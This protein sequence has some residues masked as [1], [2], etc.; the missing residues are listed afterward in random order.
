MKTEIL[1]KWQPIW[2]TVSHQELQSNGKTT[3]Y[4]QVLT[5]F[6]KFQYY[7]ISFKRFTITNL[8][9]NIEHHIFTVDRTHL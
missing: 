4:I 9:E 6:L 2:Y 5:C 1:R 8:F 7:Y 3:Q